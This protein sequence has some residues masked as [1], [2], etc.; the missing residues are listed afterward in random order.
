VDKNDPAFKKHAKVTLLECQR[1]DEF[2]TVAVSPGMALLRRV[3]NPF[4]HGQ[5]TFIELH[6]IRRPKLFFGKS[7]PM[8][9]QSLQEEENFITNTACDTM[10]MSLHKMFVAD[11]NADI[12]LDRLKNRMG[13]I[14]LSNDVDAVKQ[15][16]VS[17]A[18]ITAY[19]VLASAISAAREDAT[20]VTSTFK[21]AT[22]IR[23][24]T[25]TTTASLLS[26]ASQAIKFKWKEWFHEGVVPF[27][28]MLQS[29]N[30]QFMTEEQ[31]IRISNTLGQEQFAIYKASRVNVD[32]PVY[33]ASSLEDVFGNKELRQANILRFLQVTMGNPMFAQYIK[34]YGMLLEAGKALDFRNLKQLLMSPE[35]LMEAQQYQQA[36]GQAPPGAP[37][38]QLLQ[39]GG[40]G[41][42]GSQEEAFG[43]GQRPQNA[44][45]PTSAEDLVRS[46]STRGTQGPA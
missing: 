44:P 18:G 46:A 5:K 8:L 17:E 16:D 40:Q 12:D 21:G 41:G 2:I 43:A 15:L 6:N 10:T 23:G 35:E 14:I 26:Q 28:K 38:L 39:G 29:M 36:Y 42:Q 33:P 31:M 4:R 37:E 20:S 30:R 32:F 3:P 1:E 27:A 25:A 22:P 24:E 11:R 7:E 45:Q 13:N 19:Q 9:I 34:P